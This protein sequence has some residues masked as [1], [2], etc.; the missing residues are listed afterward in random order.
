MLAYRNMGMT[1]VA[2]LFCLGVWLSTPWAQSM[3]SDQ[4]IVYYQRV[5]QRNSFDVRTYYGLGDAYS[6]KARESG[7]VT[8]FHLAEQALRKALQIRPQYSAAL[9]HLAFVL[10]A[11]HDFAAAAQEAIKAIALDPTDAHAYGVL[12]D[13]YLEV[14]KYGQAGEAFQRMLELT[15]DLYV[16][17]RLAG[18]KSLRG[19]TTGAVEDLKQAIAAGQMEGRPQEHVA[20]AQWQLGNEYFALGNLREAEGQYRAALTTYPNYYRALAGLAQ[21]HAAQQRY[22]EAI[23]LYQQALA[24][25]P[26]PDYAAALGDVYMQ[27]G[28][29]EEARKQY[30][31]VEYIGYLNTLNKVLYNRELAA[32]Y[33]DHNM[34]L[35]E[36]LELAKKELEVRQDIYA[37]DLLAWT[38]YKNGQPYEAL[39]AMTEAL[40]LGTQDARLFFHAG[41]IYQQLGDSVKAKTYLVRALATN[42]HFHLFYAD[43]ATRTLDGLGERVGQ[44]V[45]QETGYDQ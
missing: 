14:G 28:R 24:I 36:A 33:A 15:R 25:V 23:D 43:V 10:Y 13:A 26:L 30:G 8:Y 27:L 3:T 39:A 29:P 44:V 2:G 19:D 34:K 7:D 32:F 20:W 31:L 42:P 37:Y 41:M 22:P 5:L 18:L 40:K 45:L 21:V 1:L 17:S 12:G 38:L 11:R 9:R 6:R 35:T 4:A 16:Y